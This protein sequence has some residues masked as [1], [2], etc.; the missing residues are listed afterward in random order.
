L[1]L[2]STPSLYPEIEGLTDSELFFYLALTFGLEDDPPSALEQA[3]GFIEHTG[4]RHGVEHPIQMT[5]CTTNGD[6]TWAF[7]YSSEGT[8]RTLFYSTL[9]ETL[10]A[11]YP[12]DPVFHRL[13]APRDLAGVWNEVPVRARVLH[14]QRVELGI[15]L[16]CHSVSSPF[17]ARGLR[18]LHARLL[19]PVL[20]DLEGTPRSA[21]ST[22]VIAM[23]GF[24]SGHACARE[25]LENDATP[26]TES[27]GPAT[28]TSPC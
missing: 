4:R 16:D 1:R 5:V 25:L 9:V 24:L 26:S 17:V 15:C 13:G 6:S 10:R 14:D 20:Q 27:R 8:S 22:S 18:R 11:Q 12:D 28:P 2:P 21:S 7:R 19:D 3:V 23:R